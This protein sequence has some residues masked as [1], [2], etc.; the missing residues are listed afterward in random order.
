MVSERPRPEDDDE[1]HW[2]QVRHGRRALACAR[3][4]RSIGHPDRRIKIVAVTGTN[5]KTTTV[6]LIDSMLRAAGYADGPARER[7]STVWE[8]EADSGRQHDA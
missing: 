4:W 7:S 5:G 3:R 6:Y 2:V 8:T 1:G